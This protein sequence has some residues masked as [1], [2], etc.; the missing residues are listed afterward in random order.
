MEKFQ[1]IIYGVA[2]ASLLKMKNN[3]S[4]GDDDI[5]IESIKEGDEALKYAIRKLFYFCLTTPS[6]WHNALIVIIHK[7]GDITDLKNYRSISQLSHI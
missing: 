6:Q 5:A 2:G 3:R 7:K 4:P 1:R